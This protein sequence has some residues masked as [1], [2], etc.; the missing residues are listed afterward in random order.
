VS[1]TIAIRTRFTSPAL[2]KTRLN[3]GHVSSPSLMLPC[4]SHPALPLPRPSLNLFLSSDSELTTSLLRF[5]CRPARG[6]FI[7]PSKTSPLAPSASSPKLPSTQST[8]IDRG[9]SSLVQ[10]LIDQLVPLAPSYSHLHP[11]PHTTL[12]KMS[13]RVALRPARAQALKA[14]SARN[15]IQ[16]IAMTDCGECVTH[17]SLVDHHRLLSGLPVF[18]LDSWRLLPL[19]PS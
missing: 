9:R 19:L 6:W 4:R 15:P 10:R 3:L 2:T 18:S 11:H 7:P 1:S 13:F 17:I 16:L 8:S 14:V 12:N 5:P